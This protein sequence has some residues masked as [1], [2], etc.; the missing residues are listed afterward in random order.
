LVIPVFGQNRYLQFNYITPD[1]GLPSS[2]ITSLC[3]D[4]KGYM[5]IGTS[6]GLVRYDGYSF[7]VF[8]NDPSDRNSISHNLISSILEDTDGNMLVGTST[9]LSLYNWQTDNFYNYMYEE[10]SALFGQ[11][12]IVRRITPDSSDNLWLATNIGLIYFNR[13]KNNIRIYAHQSAEANSIGSND[14]FF[15]FIETENRIWVET[16]QGLYLL[17]P[18]SGIFDHV[19]GCINQEFDIS[20]IAFTQIV[21]DN[22]GNIWFSSYAGLYCLEKSQPSDT[23]KIPLLVRYSNIPGDLTSLS[24]DRVI[25]LFVDRDGNLWVGTENGG[26]NL[27]NNTTRKFTQYHSD[28]YNSR[29]LNNESIKDITQDKAGNL[30]VGTFAGGINISTLNSEAIREIGRAH[31]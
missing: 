26:L 8:K 22:Q 20:N 13:Q 25:S 1:D 15:A 27:F 12:G 16:R 14:V 9:G 23:M 18:S 28:P 11:T 7:T 17:H 19:V 6:N 2:S 10:S 29:S 4:G 5:W 30:W 21:N 31:V 3:Q 24:N